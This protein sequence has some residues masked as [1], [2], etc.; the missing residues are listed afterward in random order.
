M[1]QPFVARN[2][3]DICSRE[4]LSFVKGNDKKNIP[5]FIPLSFWLFQILND[6]VYTFVFLGI[7]Q[8]LIS[9]KG[10][11]GTRL[12]KSKHVQK[13]CFRFVT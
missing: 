7:V 9:K 1:S 4:K 5:S 8:S 2:L 6:L 13:W 10:I 12:W 3:F 11:N